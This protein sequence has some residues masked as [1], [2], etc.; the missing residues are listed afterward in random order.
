MKTH[1]EH[2]F[3]ESTAAALREEID[4]GSK[5]LGLSPYDDPA[6][7]VAAVDTFTVRNSATPAASSS[8][9]EKAAPHRISR[10]FHRNHGDN[11]SILAFADNRLVATTRKM[12]EQ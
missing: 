11:L 2:P 3:P 10:P 4:A 1:S 8:K 9:V 12:A 5:L 7:I 6:K